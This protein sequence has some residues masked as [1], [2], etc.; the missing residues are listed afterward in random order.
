M[1]GQRA[2]GVPELSASGRGSP[3]SAG[4][5]LLAE[6]TEK[7]LYEAALAVMMRLVFLFCAEERRLLLLGDPL[8]CRRRATGSVAFV[9]AAS[10]CCW[11]ERCLC[12]AVR[13]LALAPVNFPAPVTALRVSGH[14]Q[15]G[16]RPSRG[17]TVRAPRRRKQL[18]EAALRRFGTEGYEAATTRSIA[19]DAGV[20]ETV[21]FWHFPTKHDLLLAV[22]C[23]FGPRELFCGVGSGERSEVGAV[24]ALSDLVTEYLDT[25]WQH[26]TACR[27]RA[28]V[29]G[30]D[31]CDSEVASMDRG[32]YS[33][34]CS[35]I[36]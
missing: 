35:M 4:R 20:T 23:K 8:H 30:N 2:G 3:R 32:G 26:H 36:A 10:P 34:F 22:V 5:E 9:R 28:M 17:D 6:V 19:T 12:G 1:V 24:E 33:V 15:T 29:E 31:G 25:T 13:A 21:L 18:L 16:D 11:R 27:P 14:L 7:E